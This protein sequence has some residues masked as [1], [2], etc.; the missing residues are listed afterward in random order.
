VLNA[1][2]DATVGDNEQRR[3]LVDAEPHCEVGPLLDIDAVFDKGVVVL[4]ALQ[5][6]G[7]VA[8]HSAGSAISF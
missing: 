2:L 6:L 3:N 1:G 5:H 7:E 8:L 4:A